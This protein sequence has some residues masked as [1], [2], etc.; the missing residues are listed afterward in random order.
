MANYGLKDESKISVWLEP[1]VND[2]LSEALIEA[3][4][5][6]NRTGQA[7][8]LALNQSHEFRFQFRIPPQT[9]A[10]LYRYDIFVDSPDFGQQ[11]LKLRQQLRVV[12]SAEDDVPGL[13]VMPPM[14]RENP[15][16]I[17]AGQPTVI[18]V[19]VENSSTL[20]ESYTLECDLNE[21]W[22]YVKYPNYN[23][24]LK[25]NPNRSGHVELVLHPPDS[26][27]SDL[28]Y[29]PTLRL[30]SNIKGEVV[31]DIVYFQI[32]RFYGINNEGISL[33][34]QP[35]K[36]HLPRSN[37]EANE[38]SRQPGENRQ[39]STIKEKLNWGC[40][41]VKLD[42]C[43][44]TKRS[45]F[46]KT[47]FEP[48][49][50]CDRLFVDPKLGQAIQYP[51][52]I[53]LSPGQSKNFHL[54]VK[55]K[56]RKA[57]LRRKERQFELILELQ[58]AQGYEDYPLSDRRYSG[59]IVWK[60]TP[61]WIWFLLIA[62][63]V[64]VSLW[65]A[66]WLLIL[67]F[68]LPPQPEITEFKI[69]KSQ[70]QPEE[71][72]ADE[73]SETAEASDRPRLVLDWKIEELEQ[74]DSLLLT[75]KD[76][77]GQ[78]QEQRFVFGQAETQADD[79]TPFWKFWG[80]SSSSQSE[81]ENAIPSE[82]RDVCPNSTDTRLI[83]RYPV[84]NIDLNKGYT[85]EL[86]AFPKDDRTLFGVR[87]RSSE[88]AADVETTETVS[89][90]APRIE[91]LTAQTAI[92]NTVETVTLNWQLANLDEV[93]K[94][95]VTVREQ[96]GSATVYRYRYANDS[97]TPMSETSNGTFQLQCD[98]PDPESFIN[99]DAE[100]PSADPP[101][102]ADCTWN[103]R[104]ILDPGIYT[105]KVAVFS[106]RDERVAV[107]EQETEETASLTEPKIQRFTTTETSY[108]MG[109]PVRVNWTIDNPQRV[110]SILLARKAADG[111]EVEDLP[112]LE[113]PDSPQQLFDNPPVGCRAETESD[114]LQLVC[115]GI[116]VGAYP[117]GEYRFELT[118]V[119]RHAAGTPLTQESRAVTVEPTRVG[120]G[121]SASAARAGGGAGAGSA[122]A[123][124]DVLFMPEN[125]E[126]SVDGKPVGDDP[127][128][129]V[130]ALGENGVPRTV[131]IAWNVNANG[132]DVTV[133][134]L[135][136]PGIEVNPSGSFAYPLREAPAE[137]T[138][139]LRVT[140]ELGEQATRVAVL[141]TYRS[142]G[143][144]VS[145]SAP[146]GSLGVPESVNPESLRPFEVPPQ[147]N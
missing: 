40:F 129:F 91:N 10:E 69:D 26:A 135:P 18:Q 54:W 146:P 30:S 46:I 24:S 107:D 62:S 45:F 93:S 109:E 139:T 64:G 11:P 88:T 15:H 19:Q 117:I 74:L 66:I 39:N 31:T 16:K 97:F 4:S 28:I 78:P 29:S 128:P 144:T 60:P 73:T 83:C 68:R 14:R 118:V 22:Y 44:N 136:I 77:S 96:Q 87:K 115:E 86:K 37:D 21:D 104:A 75:Y 72:P 99:T 8:T 132:R 6:M 142:S 137:I 138:V 82:L 55:P 102:S 98:Q 43:S 63:L 57:P 81:T 65:V 140:N 125:L 101:P 106:Q 41:E 116:E 127:Q 114:T 131:K 70:V 85:F 105:F 12:T 89:F 48:E 113:L 133:E 94:V 9:V 42:N 134:L 108:A 51:V 84:A 143:Q 3:W 23:D 92:E 7:T 61:G 49:G 147:A 111:S 58:N 79:S 47:L 130:Y 1:P 5:D 121:S 27:T 52:P 122:A 59:T 2:P 53:E 36:L 90:N 112:P 141:Q 124:E 56:N 110:Q 119:P 38:S 67:L 32:E 126:L 20:V 17:P 35:Q 71:D 80:Q 103:A 123:G 34:L 50:A 120:G 145:P 76:T 25:L 13:S 95:E 33:S 100:T